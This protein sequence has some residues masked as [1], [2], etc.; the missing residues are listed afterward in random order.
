MHY[1]GRAY[2]AFGTADGAV[3]LIAITQTLQS[4]AT[5]SG[6]GENYTPLLACSIFPQQPSEPDGR[7]IS[8]I[9]WVETANKNVIYIYLSGFRG[10]DA[11]FS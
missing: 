11:P 7:A 1:V 10:A 6:I 9:Y 5:G 8:V 4:A 3:G 2:L